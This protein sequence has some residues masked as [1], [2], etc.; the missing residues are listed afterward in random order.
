MD[1]RIWLEPGKPNFPIEATNMKK[2]TDDLGKKCIN[3]DFFGHFKLEFPYSLEVEK[4]II[5]TQ[6]EQRE[7]QYLHFREDVV[8]LRPR[9]DVAQEHAIDLWS[10]VLLGNG[11]IL[12]QT[13][14]R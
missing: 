12:Q 8:Q 1:K 3:C 11:V 14:V 5:T 13:K 6:R 7:T 10:E 4:V 9:A 2:A